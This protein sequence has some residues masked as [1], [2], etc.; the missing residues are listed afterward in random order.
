MKTQKQNKD[1]DK[2]NKFV[3]SIKKG[4]IYTALIPLILGAGTACNQ[5]SYSDK[6][7]QIEVN[8]EW[9]PAEQGITMIKEKQK[10]EEKQRLESLVSPRIESI[11]KEAIKN[12]YSKEGRSGRIKVIRRS[13]WGLWIDFPRLRR[14]AELT[15]VFLYASIING[16]EQ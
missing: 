1:T 15:G 16:G 4:L 12:E 2:G 14:S 9:V 8:G 6:N 11:K 3:N 7:S 5:K 13:L 10:Q